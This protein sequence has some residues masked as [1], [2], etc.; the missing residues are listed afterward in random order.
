VSA[1]SAAAAAIAPGH[2]APA[3]CPPCLTCALSSSLQAAQA[4]RAAPTSPGASSGSTSCSKWLCGAHTGFCLQLPSRSGVN[5]HHAGRCS[6]ALL[7]LHQ[8]LEAAAG[9][10]DAPSLLLLSFLVTQTGPRACWGR[11]WPTAAATCSHL[12]HIVRHAAPVLCC[13]GAD[14]TRP[15][16]TQR[17]VR[18]AVCAAW[19]QRTPHPTCASERRSSWPQKQPANSLNMPMERYRCA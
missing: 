10:I 8:A 7:A 4:R 17:G 2:V 3:L 1:P 15:L 19:P 18:S 6:A 9:C 16:Q 11:C 5:T 13:D 14:G 12:E